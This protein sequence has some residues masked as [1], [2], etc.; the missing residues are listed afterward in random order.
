[1]KIPQN[2]KK[3]STFKIKNRQITDTL[4]KITLILINLGISKCDIITMKPG[5]NF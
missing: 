1:M 5:S 3:S 2:D 4:K